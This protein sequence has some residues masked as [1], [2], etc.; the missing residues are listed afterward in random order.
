L[1]VPRPL[2]AF[3]AASRRSRA[4]DLSRLHRADESDDVVVPRSHES[5][6]ADLGYELALEN[7][8]LTEEESGV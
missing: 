7:D 6:R 5:T 3:S 8:D 1:A 4:H 2:L